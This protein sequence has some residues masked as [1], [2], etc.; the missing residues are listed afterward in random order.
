[1]RYRVSLAHRTVASSLARPVALADASA[2]RSSAPP[3]VCAACIVITIMEDLDALIVLHLCGVSLHTGRATTAASSALSQRRNNSYVPGSTWDGGI[4]FSDDPCRCSKRRQSMWQPP[5]RPACPRP[6][7]AGN[8]SGRC[9]LSSSRLP[10]A[11]CRMLANCWRQDQRPPTSS[12]PSDLTWM[13]T[14]CG[15]RTRSLSMRAFR[16]AL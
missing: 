10:I 4:F 5:R 7:D 3:L 14:A 2:R 15:T 8:G 9:S 1:M 16:R 13:S 11:R 6:R 12:V